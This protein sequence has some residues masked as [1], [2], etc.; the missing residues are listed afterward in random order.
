AVSGLLPPIHLALGDHI[1]VL[2]YLF[3]LAISHNSEKRKHAG[4]I[5][6]LLFILG[7]PEVNCPP[8]PLP[9]PLLPSH[10]GSVHGTFLTSRGACSCRGHQFANSPHSDMID[11]RKPLRGP[12]DYYFFFFKCSCRPRHVMKKCRPGQLPGSPVPKT[13]PAG[14]ATTGLVDMYNWTMRRH[15]SDQPA[16]TNT[17]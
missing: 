15:P 4:I 3:V 7:D 9:F 5:R 2:Y 13:A 17:Q 1:I 6:L 10:S 16:S 12:D 14:G 8:R 11:N